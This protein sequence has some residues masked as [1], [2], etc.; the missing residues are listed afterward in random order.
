MEGNGM[1]RNGIAILCLLAAVIFSDPFANAEQENETAKYEGSDNPLC[2]PMG[3]FK[4]TPPESVNQ[5]R[6]SVDFPHS[7]HFSYNCTKCHHKWDGGGKIQTCTTSGCH[8]QVT[9]PPKPLK[10]GVYTTD[11]IKYYKY[12]YHNQCRDCH[13]ELKTQM[14]ERTISTSETKTDLPKSIPTGCIECHPKE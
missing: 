13:R 8:D 3:N 11:A 9:I 4:I 5:I 14:T 12:A 10:N 2:I 7:K 6:A 1:R